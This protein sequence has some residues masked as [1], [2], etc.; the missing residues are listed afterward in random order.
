LSYA[1][2][3]VGW[4]AVLLVLRH[5]SSYYCVAAVHLLLLGVVQA[6]CSCVPSPRFCPAWFCRL[7][8]PSY[9]RYNI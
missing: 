2:R 9:L 1:L 5:S 3:R 8:V 4:V 7:S 6:V